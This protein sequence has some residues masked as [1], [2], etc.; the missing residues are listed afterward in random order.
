MEF[1]RQGYSSGLSFPPPGGLLDPGIKPESLMSP[2]LQADSLPSESPGN[3][4]ISL[5]RPLFIQFSRILG[6]LSPFQS[7]IERMWG[8][9][10]ILNLR[11]SLPGSIRKP[12]GNSPLQT[13]G[14]IAM[15]RGAGELWLCLIQALTLWTEPPASVPSSLIPSP[16]LPEAEFRGA[17]A[18]MWRAGPFR[19]EAMV[20][21]VKA[22]TWFSEHPLCLLGPFT[23]SRST[24]RTGSGARRRAP[25]D[26]SSRQGGQLVA[27]FLP[28]WER[29]PASCVNSILA[30]GSA[31][32]WVQR[33]VTH[34]EGHWG[35]GLPGA[36]PPI[37]TDHREEGGQQGRGGH[38]GGDHLQLI[39]WRN[40]QWGPQDCVCVW[41]VGCYFVFL[42]CRTWQISPGTIS[43]PSMGEQ[44]GMQ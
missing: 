34:E 32:V 11:N 33:A 16:S 22:A 13:P 17:G 15:N 39:P 9:V 1:S 12:V 29:L 14:W 37:S 31:S 28:G 23:L 21:K 44:G 20:G 38:T 4:R 6:I 18:Q 27:G 7:I 5:N 19:R 25:G 43:F 41:G 35:S 8:R 26:P 10:Q 2:E 3:Q 24:T 36:F 30:C 42:L 40:P